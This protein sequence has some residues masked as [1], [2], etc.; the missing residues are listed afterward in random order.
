MAKNKIISSS[1]YAVFDAL[2]ALIA[3]FFFIEKIA[4][5]AYIPINFKTIFYIL[6]IPGFWV[7]L[8]SLNDNFPLFYLIIQRQY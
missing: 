8:Y 5:Y 3:I 2:S 7:I 1:I 6:A 4:P